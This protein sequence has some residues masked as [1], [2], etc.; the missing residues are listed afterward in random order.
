MKTGRK[1]QGQNMSLG[2]AGTKSVAF[3]LGHKSCPTKKRVRRALERRV[4]QAAKTACQN[5]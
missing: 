3:G 2:E 1:A 4:R 5:F